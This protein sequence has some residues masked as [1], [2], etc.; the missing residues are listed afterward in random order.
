VIALSTKQKIID[1]AGQILVSEGYRSLSMRRIAK[2]CKI[3][4]GNLTYHFPTADRLLEA[5]IQNMLEGYSE[6]LKHYEELGAPEGQDILDQL[7]EFIIRDAVSSTTS[8]LMI[9]LWAMAKHDPSK[10][11]YVNMAYEMGS[12][13]I[14]ALILRV[15]PATPEAVAQKAAVTMLV[16]SEGSTA[17]FSRQH[18]LNCE[19]EDMIGLAKQTIRTMISPLLIAAKR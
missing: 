8:S 15:S 18:N 2:A 7:I 16:F 19:A 1:T 13:V 5:V 10:A 9:E 11:K 12:Q 17:L 6:Q 4:V 14:K 3:S